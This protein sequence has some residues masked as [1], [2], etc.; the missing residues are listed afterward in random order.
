MG[1]YDRVL[2]RTGWGVPGAHDTSRS[3]A[4]ITELITLSRDP[5]PRT[6]KIAVMNLCPCHV[7][8]NIPDAW[9][10]VLAMTHDPDPMVRR[11]V[12]HM[13]ADGSPQERSAEVVTALDELRGDPD[14]IVRRDVT[15]VLA[16]YRR[17]GRINVL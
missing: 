4:E 12:V 15:R 14:R 10:R 7:R 3:R 11:A 5:D 17:T 1:K 13:L 8:A 6:R 16:S 2:E 9:D